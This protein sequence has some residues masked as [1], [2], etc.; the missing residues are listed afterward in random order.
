MDY[1][2]ATIGGVLGALCALTFVPLSRGCIHGEINVTRNVQRWR[3][4]VMPGR[5]ISRKIRSECFTATSA[6]DAIAKFIARHG[7]EWN[8]GELL[9]VP[10]SEIA[11]SSFGAEYEP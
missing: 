10:V 6:A 1:R 4:T 7:R 11:E 5:R 9:A 3:V 8:E 2:S